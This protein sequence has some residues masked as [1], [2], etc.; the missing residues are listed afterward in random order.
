MG[1]FSAA[2]YRRF[3]QVE[4]EV[5]HG[6]RFSINLELTAS[7]KDSSEALAEFLCASYCCKSRCGSSFK[8][9]VF[10]VMR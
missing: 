1:R 6:V 5:A 8:L 9:H 7:P 4:V 10:M 2:A 3:L